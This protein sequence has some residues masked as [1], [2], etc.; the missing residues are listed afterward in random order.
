MERACPDPAAR[1]FLMKQTLES[2]A[3]AEKLAPNTWAATLLEDGIRL[4][5]G[6]V[7]AFT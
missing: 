4:N 2:I 6:Q 1:R 7:E 3:V 5:V